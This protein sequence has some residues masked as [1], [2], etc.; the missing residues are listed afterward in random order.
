MN[1][2]NT[3]LEI[4]EWINYLELMIPVAKEYDKRPAEN[5]HRMKMELKHLV[6]RIVSLRQRI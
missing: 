3:V 6:K 2:K 1:G 5:S 4:K